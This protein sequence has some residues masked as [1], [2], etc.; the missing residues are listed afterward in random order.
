MFAVTAADMDALTKKPAKGADAAGVDDWDDAEG[1]LRY[2]AGEVLDGRY[3]VTARQGGGVFSSVVRA[4]DLRARRREVVIKII[5]AKETM[6]RAAQKELA[7]LRRLAAADPDDRRHV[8]RLER[9]FEHRGHLCLVFQA[10]AC[11][12]REVIGNY[13]SVGLHVS[14]VRVFARHLLTALRLLLDCGILHGDIKPDNILVNAR[15]TSVKLCDLGS[16][17]EISE[18]DITPYLV[19]RFYRAPEIMLGARYDQAADMWSV[20]CVL[21]ELFTG[22]VAFP[23]ADNNDMLRLIQRARGPF[24]ARMLRA[25]SLRADHFDDSLAFLERSPDAVSGLV[26][27]TRRE[28]VRADDPLEARLA[29]AAGGAED[30]AQ[31]RQLADLVGRMLAPN[32]ARR[33]TVDEALAH[34]FVAKQQQ[35]Q[36]Q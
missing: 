19:S 28:V 27:T 22:G 26:L 5:R 4:A 30:R 7:F 25:A 15:E 9:S 23:G 1:Y 3:E 6:L 29:A 32:P 11:N 18:C 21:F 14:A 36:Q 34:A 20:G 24:P 12:L 33:I 35:Q 17:A 16:A 8:A 2:R 10:E 31:V 13:G